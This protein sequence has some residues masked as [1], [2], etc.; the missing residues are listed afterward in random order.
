MQLIVDCCKPI[1]SDKT[2]KI[3]DVMG[4]YIPPILFEPVE[5]FR[6]YVGS[7]RASTKLGPKI[8]D[9]VRH[10]GNLSR[11]RLVAASWN[12]KATTLSR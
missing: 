8:D 9:Y 4:L 6:M 11:E 2:I 3:L 12:L 7:G 10:D 5:V 1:A